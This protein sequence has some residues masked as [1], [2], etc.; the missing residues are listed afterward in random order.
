MMV[1]LNSQERYQEDF[2]KLGEE[3]GLKIVEVWDFG[4]TGLVEFAIKDEDIGMNG[5][6][7]VSVNGN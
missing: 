4:D 6:A 1:M 3:A 5:H 7:K 2:S